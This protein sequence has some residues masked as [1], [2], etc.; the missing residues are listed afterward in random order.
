MGLRNREVF[1]GIWIICNILESTSSFY[2]NFR[3]ECMS[4]P[5]NVLGVSLRQNLQSFLVHFLP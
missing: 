1:G 4:S 3:P 2:R 5:S